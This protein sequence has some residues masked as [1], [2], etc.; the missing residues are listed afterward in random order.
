MSTTEDQ[1]TLE[2]EHLGE[3]DTS[4][5]NY[6]MRAEREPPAPPELRFLTAPGPPLLEASSLRPGR[7]HPGPTPER[8]RGHPRRGRSLARRPG[9]SVPEQHKPSVVGVAHVAKRPPGRKEQCP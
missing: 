9:L 3:K 4:P 1:E 7:R 5:W 8:L 6:N 2:K